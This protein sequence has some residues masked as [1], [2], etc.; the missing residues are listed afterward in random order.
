MELG[1]IS[2]WRGWNCQKYEPL[3]VQGIWDTTER[4]LR[5]KEELEMG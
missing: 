5:R 1:N 4:D 3:R 2:D